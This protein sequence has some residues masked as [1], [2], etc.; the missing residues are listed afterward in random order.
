[1]KKGIFK[2]ELNHFNLRGVLKLNLTLPVVQDF[3]FR[4]DRLEFFDAFWYSSIVSQFA[5]HKN[6][7]IWS[8]F[9]CWPGSEWG[10]YFVYN[11]VIFMKTHRDTT[12]K[13]LEFFKLQLSHMFCHCAEQKLYMSHSILQKTE[14]HN[15]ELKIYQIREL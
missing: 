2:I 14:K 8:S 9:Q 4:I 15:F 6:V 1:M 3:F 13:I 10:L 11:Y 12:L 5:L 7:Q